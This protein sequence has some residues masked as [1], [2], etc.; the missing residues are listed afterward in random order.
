[1]TPVSGEVKGSHEVDIARWLPFD[2][3]RQ[4]L[5]YERDQAVLDALPEALGPQP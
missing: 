4:M 1:M 3:A 2:R 5:S